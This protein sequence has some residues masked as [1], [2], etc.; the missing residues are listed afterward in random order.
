MIY[1]PDLFERL[2]ELSKILLLVLVLLAK[3][4]LLLYLVIELLSLY[5]LVAV[6]AF[7]S[8]AHAM[9]RE[10]GRA[11]FLLK[12]FPRQYSRSSSLKI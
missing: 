10:I 5:H 2:A 3:K 4:G 8:D 1:S 9:L 11:F 12:L 7:F 6:M